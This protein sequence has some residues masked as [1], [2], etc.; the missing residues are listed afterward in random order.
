MHLI[1]PI[2]IYLDSDWD[3]IPKISGTLGSMSW[4]DS[5]AHAVYPHLTSLPLSLSVIHILNCTPTNYNLEGAI[6]IS[7]LKYLRMAKND[8]NICWLHRCALHI[9]TLMGQEI[10]VI[11]RASSHTTGSLTKVSESHKMGWE[12]HGKW[13][14]PL[15]HHRIFTFT[16][17]FENPQS[18]STKVISYCPTL[19]VVSPT[20]V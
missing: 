1:I 7:T 6:N 15:F 5:G 14:M 16:Q 18:V 2:W 13:K 11:I 17:A 10:Y 19:L 3:A 9:F 12:P 8:A 4:V 20:F